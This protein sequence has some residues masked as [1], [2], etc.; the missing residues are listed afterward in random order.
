MASRAAIP[1]V[2]AFGGPMAKATAQSVAD[3]GVKHAR[4]PLPYADRIGRAFGAN[5]NISGVRAAIGGAAATASARM[6]TTGGYAT[7][8]RIAFARPPSLRVAAHEAAHVI[9]QRSGLGLAG[10]VGRAGDAHERHA[11]AVADRVVRGQSASDLLARYAGPMPRSV[12]GP[13]AMPA[14][15]LTGL[16]APAVQLWNAPSKAPWLATGK[17]KSAM[18]MGKV[19]SM[20]AQDLTL[21]AGVVVGAGGANRPTARPSSWKTLQKWKMTHSN[22][23]G[24]GGKPGY[25]RMHMLSDRLGGPGNDKANLAPGTNSMNQKHYNRA[26]KKL[27]GILDGG[28][29]ILQYRV[30]PKYQFP[31]FN[32]KTI[33]GDN[34]WEDTLRRLWWSAKY[35]TVA[36][37]GATLKMSGTISE[38]PKLDTK[39][40]WTK[41]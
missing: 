12:E 28:G 18:N 16:G 40:N 24:V 9:Q 20:I 41:H 5:H 36:G 11:D 23:K 4:S 30:I 10:G 2:Q 1:L 13:A 25:V 14:G 38:K 39:A 31:S 15:P 29:E 32:L 35:K 37:A 8:E 33:A 17:W 19:S 22:K 7:R 34:A 3:A 27:I 26:E 21:N 6:G